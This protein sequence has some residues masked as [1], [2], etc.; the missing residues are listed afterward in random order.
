MSFFGNDASVN[1]I[2]FGSLVPRRDAQ[3]EGC[4]RIALLHGDSHVTRLPHAMVASQTNGAQER[5]SRVG[6]SV[7]SVRSG[8][9]TR[10]ASA[11]AKN[12]LLPVS[13]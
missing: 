8:C 13:R 6:G 9:S 1:I 11:L 4:N 5:A 7:S 10:G 2:Y 3:L 12:P